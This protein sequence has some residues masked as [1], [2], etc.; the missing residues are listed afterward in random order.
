MC[1]WGQAIAYSQNI[2]DA[3][4]MELEPGFLANEPLAYEAVARAQ[5]I[6]ADEG[7]SGGSEDGPM[8]AR[9]VALVSALARKLVATVDEYKSHFVDG[10]PASLNTAYAK[11]MAEAAVRSSDEDWPDHPMVL[12]VAGDAW[13]NLS[14]WDCEFL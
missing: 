5:K 7:A 6:L 12:V 1:E 11:A 13:M 9:D 4:V 3:T 14:P 8:K 2:N 10:L